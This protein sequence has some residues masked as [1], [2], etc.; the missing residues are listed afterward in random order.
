MTSTLTLT[1]PGT[2][3]PRRPETAGRWKGCGAPGRPA[4]EEAA[5]DFPD[6]TTS[7]TGLYKG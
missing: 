3:T 5:R 6:R 2:G 1:A 7:G 4:P